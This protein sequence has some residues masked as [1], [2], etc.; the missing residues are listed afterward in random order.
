MAEYDVVLSYAEEDAGWAGKLADGLTNEGV[1]VRNDPTGIAP[2]RQLQAWVS[3]DAGEDSKLILVCSPHY[4]R[5]EQVEPLLAG[6]TRT[7][8]DQLKIQRPLLLVVPPGL[9]L[10]SLPEGLSTLDF[11]N[12]DDF[13]LR[14]RQLVEALDI[15]P[16][17]S[18]IKR[19][20]KALS[21]WIGLEKPVLEFKEQIAE[22]YR[23][24]GFVVKSN[25]E[26][27]DIKFDLLI[28]KQSVGVPS[29]TLIECVESEPSRQQMEFLLAK[30]RLVQNQAPGTGCMLVTAQEISDEVRANLEKG[31]IRATTYPD[32]LNS[33]LPMDRYVERLLAE[34]DG[35]R[36]KKWRGEDW[37]IRPDVTTDWQR[38]R[39][40]AL[41]P[42]SAWLG[43]KRG[44]LL[45]LLGDLG[46]GK[47][48]LADFL[49]YEMG[50]AYQKD[51]L[52]HP[53]PVLIKLHNVQK[54]ISLESIVITHFS[55][56][57]EKQQMDEFSFSRFEYLV[58]KGR[59]VLLFD[60]FD[61]MAE[62]LRPQVMRDNLKELIR[63]VA[64]GGKVLLTAR[65]HYFQNR[66]EQEMLLGK[67]A[68]YLQEFTDTQVQ[69]YLDKARPD[70]K[71]EDWRKIQEIYNLKKLVERPLL[72]DMVVMTMPKAR[73]VNAATLYADYARI[74]IDR[75][76][77]KGRLLDKQVKLRLMI[78]LAW[79]IWHEEKDTIHVEYLLQAIRDLKEYKDLNF[80]F[81]TVEEVT[82]EMRTASFLKRND[83]GHYYF[84]DPSFEE[85]FLACKIYE[86]L[87][88]PNQLAQIKAVLRTKRFE[89]KVIFF[90]EKLITEDGATYE[91]FREI[92]KEGY[93]PEVSENALQILYWSERIRLGMEDEVTDHDAL[94]REFGKHIPRKAKL[95]GARLKG[96]VLEASDLSEV[97]FSGADL[98][99]ANLN[100]T[101]LQQAC[102][103]GAILI[104][105]KLEDAQAVQADF[106]EAQLSRAEFR[107][108]NLENAD[109]TGVINRGIV[110]ENNQSQGM[111]GRNAAGGLRPS[112]YR[113]MAQQGFSEG[114]QA[115]ALDA[116]I[117]LCASSGPDGLITIFRIQDGRLL[118]AVEG[119][120]GRVVSLQ[121]SPSGTLLV[122]G[123]VDGAVRLWS[124]SEG[125]PLNGHEEHTGRVNAVQFSLDRRWVASGGDDKTLRLWSVDNDQIRYS[126]GFQGDDSSIT[127]LDFSFDGKLLASASE[128]GS[129]RIWDV[130]TGFMVQVF[131]P[132]EKSPVNVLKF[133]PNGRLLCVGSADRLIRLWS[134]VG[135]GR[136]LRT[137]R[138]HEG[139]VAALDFSPD[140]QTLASGGK[141]GG[142]RLW[143]AGERDIYR[144]TDALLAHLQSTG[145][146]RTVMERLWQLRNREIIG[147]EEFL[148]LLK[149]TIGSLPSPDLVSQC[150]ENALVAPLLDS[151]KKHEDWVGAIRF[152]NDGSRLASGGTDRQ[153]RLWTVRGNRFE[154][155]EAPEGHIHVKRRAGMRVVRIAPNRRMI[156]SGGDDARIYL[157]PSSENDLLRGLAGHTNAVRTLDVS[158]DCRMIASGSDD[159]T[160][161]FWSTEDGRLT[162]TI[163]GHKGRVTSVRFSPKDGLLASGSDDRT[164][165]LWLAN[166]GQLSS[167]LTGH[168]GAV[169]T[170]RFSPDGA[171]LA[172]GSEDNSVC[173]WIAAKGQ[174]PRQ[175]RKLEGH[176]AGVH[177]VHFSPDGAWLASAGRDRT[178]R[179]WTVSNVRIRQVL[180]GHTDTV[181]ALR[182]FPDGLRLASGGDDGAVRIWDLNSG[183]LQ[184]TLTGHL[185]RV[186]SIDISPNGKFLVAAGSA[187]RLQYWD[188]ETMKTLLYRYAFD[189]AAWLDLLPDGRFHASAEGRRYLCY[190]ELGELN[191]YPAEILMTEFHDPDGVREV[192]ERLHSSN[193]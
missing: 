73:S 7:Y 172:S 14:L 109:F 56:R 158:L 100:H 37:F 20:L 138:G 157:W 189:E 86:C 24:S 164:I 143:W 27:K 112:N 16:R 5:D 147:E 142:V 18:G 154:P 26:S 21:K 113:P 29:R 132:E 50:K 181:G 41:R 93:E 81:L 186:Y 40:P 122:S 3:S 126:D 185:G 180:N 34:L 110:F 116:N 162:H 33:L 118:H 145:L 36:N 15:T 152:S 17:K 105:A 72:L 139:E 173:L 111:K 43:D 128:N 188:L 169:N 107:R 65:T 89:P 161:R 88:Q 98:T 121:F 187:G 104:E 55:E 120:R 136:L 176:T 39:H 69:K 4:F 32:I 30:Y 96:I 190:T 31:W 46:T 192:I 174:P 76:K 99:G 54:A 175:Q 23:L 84:A 47:S 87:K 8:P 44:N 75:E 90:L 130:N 171:L 150:L 2:S 141:R 191:S 102:F 177:V 51:P 146:S 61:E 165:G 28:E 148:H 124:V 57:L 170:V 83:D 6:F 38:E 101:Q 179:L 151:A 115:L 155:V 106:K 127:A 11:S 91:S 163:E 140:G 9:R 182:F 67:E 114:F 63:P 97:D 49:A 178:V 12:D 144:F 117:E 25:E 45:A 153:V 68:V 48:T 66:A 119:H 131:C 79:R 159:R 58:G 149:T 137:L 134:V 135:Q 19:Y 167:R 85:Y 193:L 183:S 13:E 62:R 92:L 82:E 35:Q 77:G 125:Q 103:R 166:T 123:G 59:I 184:E 156:L 52:R 74:W 10:P 80:G 78:E 168:Q 94:R 108:A 1:R 95:A 160:I 70:T 71:E 53:A 60:A 42:I 22:L 133:S 129:I 64:N